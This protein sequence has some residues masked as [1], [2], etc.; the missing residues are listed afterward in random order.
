MSYRVHREGEYPPAYVL[1]ISETNSVDVTCTSD[2]T[3]R[4]S[5]FSLDIRSA[6]CVDL[7]N[8]EEENERFYEIDENCDANVQKVKVAAGQVLEGAIVSDTDSDGLYPNNA[9]QVWDIF[10]DANQVHCVSFNT[11]NPYISCD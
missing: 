4:R 5:G 2:S 8:L 10:T 6:S 11:N 7:V 3:T 9:C 1:F